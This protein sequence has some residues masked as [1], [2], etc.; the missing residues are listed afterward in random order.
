VTT[1]EKRLLIVDD[2]PDITTSLKLGLERRGMSVTV[3]NDPLLA[4]EDFRRSHEYDLVITDINMP[5]MTGF[6]LYR[7]MRKVESTTPICFITAFDI[8]QGEFDQMFPNVHVA[9][10]LKKPIG[11]AELAAHIEQLTAIPPAVA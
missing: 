1:L 10:F 9:A 11:V 8:Y 6:E 3:F 2:E 5:Q 7:E 4:L